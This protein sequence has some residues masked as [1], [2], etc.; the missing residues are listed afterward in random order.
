MLIFQTKTTACRATAI[1]HSQMHPWISWQQSLWLDQALPIKFLNGGIKSKDDCGL[2]NCTL[3]EMG[4]KLANSSPPNHAADMEAMSVPALSHIKLLNYNKGD[5]N[6]QQSQQSIPFIKISDIITGKVPF[7]HPN[8]SNTKH[9]LVMDEENLKASNYT[10]LSA[11]VTVAPSTCNGHSNAN[12]NDG[13]T[14]E[15]WTAVSPRKSGP[16][17]QQNTAQPPRPRAGTQIHLLKGTTILNQCLK[18]LLWPTNKSI[19]HIQA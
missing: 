18:N 7:P 8:T 16:R 15:A 2:G 12:S 13:T 1:P 11:P 14:M 9:T 5:Q 10:R 19:C 3:M 6:Q 4:K 17:K